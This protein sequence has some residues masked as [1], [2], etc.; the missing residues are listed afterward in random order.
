[1]NRTPNQTMF[2]KDVTFSMVKVLAKQREGLKICHIN[3][4]SLNNK[5][6]E[7]RFTFENS[8]V[9]I[10]CVSETWFNANTPDSLL[11]LNGFNIFRADRE[12]HGGGVAIY[13]NKKL[14]S[15]LCRKSDPNS[16]IEYIFCEILS[17]NNRI[18]VGCVY[19]PNRN[20]SF[21]DFF[22]MLEITTV[23]FKDIIIAGDFN[24]NILS[25]S[26]L[27]DNMLPLGLSSTNSSM[28]THYTQ[29]TNTLLDLFFVS[30][31]SRVLLY[32][33]ISAPC[34]SKHDLIFLIYNVQVQ[35]FDQTES[36]RD[37]K[38]IDFS[39]LEEK[40]S[41]IDWNQIYTELSVDAKLKFLHK[42]ILNLYDNTI[43]IKK[44]IIKA[45]SRP[46][47]TAIVKDAIVNRDIAYIR[48]K[49]FKTCDLLE[50]YHAARRDANSK[51]KMAKIEYYH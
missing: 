39:L 30:E 10:I 28:P 5:M 50:E 51:I 31:S 20:I 34:F 1:M 12:R 15:K 3:A 45:K 40:T 7:L 6:D 48:W 29:T 33:Q 35:H 42:N 8:G 4:Q 27:L 24:S 23:S 43:S 47:F 36:Y 38:N 9:D 25:E 17:F 18:L 26:I 46:W 22:H 2:S 41:E 16:P 37:F 13:I 49:R 44:V 19:R 32:D 21:G 14:N 11:S